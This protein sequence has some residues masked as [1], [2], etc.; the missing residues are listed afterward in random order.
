M[1]VERGAVRSTGA[2][3]KRALRIEIAVPQ[4]GS[5]ARTKN[6]KVFFADALRA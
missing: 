1:M 2:E 6:T 4:D 5:G 3:E